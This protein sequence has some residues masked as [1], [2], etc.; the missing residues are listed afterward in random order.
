LLERPEGRQ[1]PEDTLLFQLGVTQQ[2]LGR[3]EQAT[4]TFRRLVEEF[5]RS[6]L[7]AEA[8]RLAGGPGAI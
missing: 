7:Q 4:A 2:A 1:L 5:P 6:P 8:R 3:T